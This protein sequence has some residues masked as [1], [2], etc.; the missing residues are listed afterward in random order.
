MKPALA[1]IAVEV[2]QEVEDQGMAEEDG[3]AFSKRHS[4]IRTV[5]IISCI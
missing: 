5:V 4:D 3:D 1:L 2:V